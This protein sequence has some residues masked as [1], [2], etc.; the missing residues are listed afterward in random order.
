MTLLPTSVTAIDVGGLERCATCTFRVS[1]ST[2]KCGF[3]F[4]L[5]EGVV[6]KSN[7]IELLRSI[8][9]TFERYRFLRK[10]TGPARCR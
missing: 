4:K 7:G 3:D 6:T 10:T 9:W 8:A 2:A 5:H 1:S